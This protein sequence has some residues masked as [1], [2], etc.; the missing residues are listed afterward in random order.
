MLATDIHSS[1]AAMRLFSSEMLPLYY[2]RLLPSPPF[3]LHFTAEET[4]FTDWVILPLCI[5]HCLYFHLPCFPS[6]LLNWGRSRL[7]WSW[8]PGLHFL[9]G[10]SDFPQ[11]NYNMHQQW[12]IRA[13][14]NKIDSTF[15]I[16]ESYNN[17][18]MDHK[19][20]KI[21]LAVQCTKLFHNTFL[22]H[23]KQPAFLWL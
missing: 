5:Y 15:Y 7:T 18:K 20:Q 2:S 13:I 4:D 9:L 1:A 23:A 19:T 14:K 12:G 16:L 11:C 17:L 21:K 22:P 6:S 10:S 3:L 8:A